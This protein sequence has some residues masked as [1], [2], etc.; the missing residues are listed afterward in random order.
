MENHKG[1]TMAAP[2]ARGCQVLPP[3]QRMRPVFHKA[4]GCEIFGHKFHYI[5]FYDVSH[6]YSLHLIMCIY[7]YLINKYIYIYI[8]VQ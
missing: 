8:H 6:M 3:E 7:I 1:L 4:T 2:A 5:T